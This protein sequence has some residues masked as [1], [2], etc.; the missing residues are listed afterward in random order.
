[1]SEGVTELLQ[2]AG[3]HAGYSAELLARDRVEQCEAEHD[4]ERVPACGGQRQGSKV[5]RCEEQQH[6]RRDRAAS[7]ALPPD[8]RARET[9]SRAA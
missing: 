7:G 5:P 8:A 9:V 4:Q 3:D 2:V 6:R 1:M